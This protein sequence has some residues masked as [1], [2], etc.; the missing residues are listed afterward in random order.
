MIAHA[1]PGQSE[2]RPR[3]EA[4]L[5]IVGAGVGQSSGLDPPPETVQWG[6]CLGTVWK[7]HR[8]GA[9]AGGGELA[10]CALRAPPRGKNRE[11]EGK[12]LPPRGKSK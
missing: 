8:N 10:V 3:V 5:V 6:F 7:R 2:P 1:A 4:A 9:R 11:G 12:A